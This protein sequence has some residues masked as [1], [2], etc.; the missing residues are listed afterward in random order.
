MISCPPWPKNI[1]ELLKEQNINKLNPGTKYKLYYNKVPYEVIA[2][3]DGKISLPNVTAFVHYRYEELP[4][5]R[6][7]NGHVYEEYKTNIDNWFE[8]EAQFLI[9]STNNVYQSNWSE[10]GHRTPFGTGKPPRPQQKKTT[11]TVKVQNP[12]SIKS[13]VNSGNVNASL[14]NKNLDM[15]VSGTGGSVQNIKLELK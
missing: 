8:P 14:S 4:C 15:F 2:R 13:F 9:L 6:Y 5:W 7:S 1:P 12:W 3:A 11:I 10:G